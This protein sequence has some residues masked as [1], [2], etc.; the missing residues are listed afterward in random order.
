[1][2]GVGAVGPTLL[3]PDGR[4]SAAGVAIGLYDPAVPVMSGFE[5]DADGYYGSLS[6]A[7]EVAAVGMDCLL[8]RR[9]LFEQ[10]GGFE[11][12]YSR[13]FSDF[14]L[15]MKLLEADAPAVC[16]PV[17]RTIDHTTEAQRRSDFDV[18]DRALFV[19]RWYGQLAAG[20]PYYARGFLRE[21][22]DY[23][24]SQFTGDVLEVAMK[25]AA[26]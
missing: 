21:A 9:S 13:Q 11:E 20:D 19:D 6:C 15:C 26:R 1:M 7:R 23:T 18:L 8:V 3:H 5:A 12:A 14:D 17:P 24:P 10:V 2:P 25:E 22:A 4:V 16:A